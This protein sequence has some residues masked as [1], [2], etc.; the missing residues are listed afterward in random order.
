[1]PNSSRHWARMGVPASL[2]C[3]DEQ[4]TTIDEMQDN[5]R[6]LPDQRLQLGA[7]AIQSCAAMDHIAAAQNGL[8]S[9]LLQAGLAESQSTYYALQH[10]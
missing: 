7:A 9:A 1:M 4:Q 10:A 8:T 3:M 5:A 2:A 6:L